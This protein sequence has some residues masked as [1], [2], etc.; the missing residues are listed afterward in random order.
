M[1]HLPIA[2]SWI[3]AWWT[4][5]FS[6]VKPCVIFQKNVKP[7]LNTYLLLGNLA[8]AENIWFPNKMHID[9]S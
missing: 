6:L 8:L 7:D 3:N 1:Y 4:K 2:A 5:Q 9:I